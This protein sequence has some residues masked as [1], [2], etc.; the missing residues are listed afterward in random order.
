MRLPRFR[1]RA[2]LLWRSGDP[3]LASSRPFPLPALLL[4]GV[5]GGLAAFY[6]AALPA[7]L[8]LAFL[9]GLFSGTALPGLARRCPSCNA[10]FIP[11]GGRFCPKCGTPRER[12]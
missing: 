5:T 4:A 8:L 6:P 12:R 3:A 7:R 1:N 10:P 9:A 11:L 2:D